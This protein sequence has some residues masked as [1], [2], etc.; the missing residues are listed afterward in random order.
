MNICSLSKIEKDK[1]R[2]TKRTYKEVV[3]PIPVARV[4]G[5]LQL[6]KTRLMYESNNYWKGKWIYLKGYEWN[7][8][9]L[10]R[11]LL[12]GPVGSDGPQEDSLKEK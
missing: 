1:R 12:D 4:Q 2:N 9:K 8:N 3:R 6:Q 5:E 11:N 10:K 7:M